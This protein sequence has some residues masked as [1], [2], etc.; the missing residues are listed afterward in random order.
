MNNNSGTQFVSDRLNPK[1]NLI[2]NMVWTECEGKCRKVL[3]D[4]KSL[5]KHM[6]EK[7]GFLEIPMLAQLDID[8]QKPHPKTKVVYTEKSY[9]E[10][11]DKN[12]EQ[13]WL[14][15]Q[16]IWTDIRNIHFLHLTSKG[17]RSLKQYWNE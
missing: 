9:M 14:D 3:N 15:N 8:D 7:H 5:R 4:P 6:I 1:S 11:I 2:C 16:F 17:T 10:W 13:W 12:P